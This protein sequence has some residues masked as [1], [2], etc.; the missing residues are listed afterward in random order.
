MECVCVCVI[1]IL[2]F[3]L[4]LAVNSMYGYNSVESSRYCKSVV[5]TED[6]LAGN[7]KK[8]APRLIAAQQVT[9]LGAVAAAEEDKPPSLLYC[10]TSPQEFAGIEN[11]AC[12]GS[13]ILSGSRRIFLSLISRLMASL[14]AHMCEATYTDTGKTHTLLLLLLL[15]L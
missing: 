8:A 13:M 9:L 6:Y 15:L 10:L 12:W 5:I 1:F 2:S 7:L 4:H 14:D 11:S 3:S